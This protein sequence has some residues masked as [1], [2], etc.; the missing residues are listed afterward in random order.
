MAWRQLRELMTDGMMLWRSRSQTT[1]AAMAAKR[2]EAEAR[3]AD[4]QRQLAE[5]RAFKAEATARAL[6]TARAD[7]KVLEQALAD[8]VRAKT[9]KKDRNPPA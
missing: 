4:A 9:H 1:P 3:L 6:E 5:A 2:T 8:K 7:V